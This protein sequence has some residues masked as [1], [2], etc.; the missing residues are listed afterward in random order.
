L[1]LYVDTNNNGTA[2]GIGVGADSYVITSPTNPLVPGQW[3]Q[4]TLTAD[5]LVH[6]V[7]ERNGLGEDESAPGALFS[8][9]NGF[10]K[11]GDL[12]GTSYPSSSYTWGDMT[13]F[14]AYIDSGVWGGSGGPYTAYVDDIHI[15]TV[16]EPGTLAL[17]GTL[18][19]VL[20]G[21]AWRRR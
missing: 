20:L 17:L 3:V 2:D 5:T 7:G 15:S 12:L 8:A 1:E 21:Y 13:I 10:G 11:F 9:Y 4:E 6:V 16:P 14:N 19:L 18:G